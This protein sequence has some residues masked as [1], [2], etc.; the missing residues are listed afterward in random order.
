MQIWFALGVP[1]DSGCAATEES[2]GSGKCWRSCAGARVRVA[3]RHA[4]SQ[5]Q[6]GAAM[7]P[8]HGQETGRWH[9]ASLGSAANAAKRAQPMPLHVLPES[10]GAGIGGSPSENRRRASHACARVAPLRAGQYTRAH[11]T[12]R[13]FAPSR[14]SHLGLRGTGRAGAF[15]RAL[16]GGHPAN[17][18]TFLGP[19]V[20]TS[21]SSANHR[22]PGRDPAR[23]EPNQ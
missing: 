21:P 3:V 4:L 12:A 23:C 11:G 20:A 17:A 2:P 22:P 8:E 10:I 13:L 18:R 9:E 15:V 6:H 19:A 1:G 7:R 5:R 14:S 16:P